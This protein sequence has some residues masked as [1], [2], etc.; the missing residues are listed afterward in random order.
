MLSAM[1]IPQQFSH[2]ELR[3]GTSV[4]L[5]VFSCTTTLDCRS[6]TCVKQDEPCK[7][8]RWP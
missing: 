4:K 8:D 3:I 7:G 1:I 6:F 5:A 2:L